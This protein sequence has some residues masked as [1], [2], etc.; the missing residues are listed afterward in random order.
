MKITWDKKAKAVYIYLDETKGST[1]EKTIPLEGNISVDYAYD[2]PQGI[3]IL[4]VNEIPVVER[5]DK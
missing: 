2:G 1:V 3:E 5:I 4:N